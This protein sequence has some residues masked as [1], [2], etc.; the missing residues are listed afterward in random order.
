MNTEKKIILGAIIADGTSLRMRTVDDRPERSIDKCFLLLD[1]KPLIEHVISRSQPQIDTLIINS[2]SNDPLLTSYQLPIIPDASFENTAAESVSPTH[3]FTKKMGPLAGVAS[4]MQ[5]AQKQNQTEG[6]NYQWLATFPC[7][8]PFLPLNLVDLLIEKVKKQ[9]A[10]MACGVSDERTS[11]LCSIWSLELL[12]DLLNFLAQ[13]G[14]KVKVFLE[15][16]NY[17]TVNFETDNQFDIDPF[18][19]INTRKQLEE[20][21]NLYSK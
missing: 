14:R 8:T 12:P 20:A 7:D 3:S 9:N 21:N 13:G 4:A 5:W 6:E 2:S 10:T 18:Y 11:Q 19:N 17:V 16:T 1:D 15:S